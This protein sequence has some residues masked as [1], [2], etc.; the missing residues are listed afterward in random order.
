MGPEFRFV[1]PA[2][3]GSPKG[4]DLYTT[5]DLALAPLIR[6]AAPSP[7]WFA[8]APA[9]RRKRGRPRWPGWGG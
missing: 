4:A 1:H 2:S 3:L 8:P 7:V 6:T 9:P 5:F